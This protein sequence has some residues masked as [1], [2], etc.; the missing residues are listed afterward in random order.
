MIIEPRLMIAT[1][2][3]TMRWRLLIAEAVVIPASRA[4]VPAERERERERGE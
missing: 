4:E 3:G 1:A 2:A